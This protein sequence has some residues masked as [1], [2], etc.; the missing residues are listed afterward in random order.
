C[1]FSSRRRHTRFSRDWS[2][3]VCSSDLGALADQL[4]LSPQLADLFAKRGVLPAQAAEFQRLV[5]DQLELLGAYRFG[6]IVDR[7][8]LDRRQ[9]GRASCRE[10]MASGLVAV[11]SRRTAN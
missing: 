8:R 5:D 1:F 2:S 9:I 4:A 10:R 6:E 3:D 7:A 11:Q